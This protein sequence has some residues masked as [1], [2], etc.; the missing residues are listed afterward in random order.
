MGSIWEDWEE[1]RRREKEM[2]LKRLVFGEDE[3]KEEQRE[4]YRK[5]V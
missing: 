5:R 3:K 1:E 4:N 2:A